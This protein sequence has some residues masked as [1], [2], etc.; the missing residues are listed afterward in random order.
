MRY[1]VLSDIHGGSCELERAL[2]FYDKF[3]CDFIILLGDLLN[4]G[5]RNKVPSS[6]SPNTVASL[7]DI[8]KNHIISIRGNCDSEVDSMVFSFPCN[9]PYGWILVPRSH[10]IQRIFLTHGH[11]HK[12]DSAEELEKLG[13]TKDDIVIQ[14]H[15]HI[16]GIFKKQSG[17][18]NI[19]PG[20]TTLPK[21][22]TQKGFALIDENSVKLF[23]LDGVE[24]SKYEF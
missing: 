3:S 24:L 9:A 15:T 23:N 11:L 16:S 18:V 13:L 19:N 21:G 10:G 14:G 2:T 20:S 1:L 22:G 5:P 7:L 17:I 4:H 12:H 6:Y 8:H